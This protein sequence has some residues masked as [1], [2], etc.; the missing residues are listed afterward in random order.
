[1]DRPPFHIA[2]IGCV[3]TLDPK[4]PCRGLFWVAVVMAGTDATARM[5]MGIEAR[6]RC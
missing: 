5:G 6:L 4:G 3:G 2:R 1:M